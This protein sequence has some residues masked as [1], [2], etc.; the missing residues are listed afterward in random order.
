MNKHW[1]RV[2]AIGSDTAFSEEFSAIE[3]FSCAAFFFDANG[4]SICFSHLN[5]FEKVIRNR[6]WDK[7]TSL[8]KGIKIG[9][10]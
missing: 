8:S 4:I 5:F 6:I 7:H 10:K 9:K 3:L 1:V 2:G